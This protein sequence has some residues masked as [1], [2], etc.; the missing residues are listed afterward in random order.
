MPNVSPGTAPI[1]PL[2]MN[3]PTY[4]IIPNYDPAS[5]WLGHFQRA[6]EHGADA[7]TCIDLLEQLVD[8]HADAGIDHVVHSLFEGFRTPQLHSDTADPYPVT[9]AEMAQRQAWL[10]AIMA[11]IA[12]EGRDMV[13]VLLDRCRTRHVRFLAGLRM[14]DRHL[15]SGQSQAFWPRV[16]RMVDA[17]PEWALTEF[18]GGLD[19]RYDGVR[20]A[21][22]AFIAETLERFDV[23]GIEFDWMRWCHVFPASEAVVNGPLLTDFTRQVRDMLDQAAARRGRSADDRLILGA[24]VPHTLEQCTYLGYDIEAWLKEGIVDYLAPSDFF[25]IDF[26]LAVDAF[27]ALADAAGGRCRI[28]P[29]IHPGPCWQ[30]AGPIN[31]FS[32]YRAAAKNF[33]AR[34]AHGISPYNFQSHWARQRIESACDASGADHHLAMGVQNP[35]DELATLRCDATIEEADRHYR[36]YPLWWAGDTEGHAATGAYENDR[37]M[38]DCRQANPR[39]SYT[40][41]L[42]EDLSSPGADATFTFVATQMIEADELTISINGK[43]ITADTIDRT[44]HVG[45]SPKEGRSLGRHFIYRMPLT[46]HPARYG[47][48]ELTVGLSRLGGMP[49]RVINVQD[50]EIHVRAVPG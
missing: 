20:D 28:Y 43:T 48:N 30:H 24:R 35:L 49:S 13:Q 31:D 47:H 45:R 38:L 40:F 37:L 8:A 23:D 29:S 2:P 1:E 39:G 22:L 3:N 6:H 36:Y 26:N 9:S 16:Q 50:F 15:G 21:V 19:Y 7:A 17:H 25:F 4:T 32:H 5:L 14:N 44:W 12:A 41:Y 46:A 34:G 27:A 18:P 42:A 11:S 10:Y 33:Y